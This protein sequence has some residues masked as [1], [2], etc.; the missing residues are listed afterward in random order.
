M[1]EFSTNRWIR[2]RTLRKREDLSID[3]GLSIE[4]DINTVADQNLNAGSGVAL[5][6]FMAAKSHI[7]KDLNI[8]PFFD[9]SV[10]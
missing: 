5:N 9:E 2:Y 10:D 8:F 4:I 1:D 7:E 6:F 3:T